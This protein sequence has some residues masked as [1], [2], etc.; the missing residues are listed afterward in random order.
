[1][2]DEDL[3]KFLKET[4]TRPPQTRG[5]RNAPLRSLQVLSL[6]E[7]YF[8]RLHFCSFRLRFGPGLIRSNRSAIKLIYYNC[9]VF[10]SRNF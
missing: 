6:F 7:P 5:G 8:T 1:M 9:P 2:S 3:A 10:N 4:E